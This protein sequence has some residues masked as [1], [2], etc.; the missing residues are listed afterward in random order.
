[1]QAKCDGLIAP[2]LAGCDRGTRYVPARLPCP[3]ER[4]NRGAVVGRLQR[5]VMRLP[6]A[7]E[8]TRAGCLPRPRTTPPPPQRPSPIVLRSCRCQAETNQRVRT[9]A[10]VVSRARALAG[11][12]LDVRDDP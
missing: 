11:A 3:P 10:I 9:R 8:P 4:P 5:F 12:G 1:M 6:S 2:L 7:R